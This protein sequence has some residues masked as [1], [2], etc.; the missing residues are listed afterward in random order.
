[1]NNNIKY[2]S[3]TI[4][5]S[6]DFNSLKSSIYSLLFKNQ[7]ND[8]NLYYHSSIKDVV[9]D[10]DDDYTVKLADIPLNH[11]IRCFTYDK[12]INPF[13]PQIIY[14]NS[15]NLHVY[16]IFLK[17]KIKLLF[18]N[19]NKFKDV[20]SSLVTTKD[21]FEYVNSIYNCV[22]HDEKNKGHL[23]FGITKIN[24]TNKY[25]FAYDNSV[26]DCDAVLNIIRFIFDKKN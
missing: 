17:D 21:K 18:D 13:T 10:F 22:Y 24:E 8:A 14:N 15:S 9:I 25:I 23:T 3:F 1:M 11:V 16:N 20:L 6:L 2:G 19:Y 26:F 12:N 5:Y 7:Y 4:I